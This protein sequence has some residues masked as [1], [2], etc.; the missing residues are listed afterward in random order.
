MTNP[1][2]IRTLAVASYGMTAREKAL[3]AL[4]LLADVNAPWPALVALWGWYERIPDSDPP[5]PFEE[6]T[7]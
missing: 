1:A 6:T 3:T 4:V 5:L 2:T 7:P